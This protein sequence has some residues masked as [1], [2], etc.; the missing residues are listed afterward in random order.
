MKSARM[1]AKPIAGPSWFRL[2]AQPI[3]VG[4]LLAHFVPQSLVSL[5][6]RLALALPFFKSGLTRWDGFLH[7]SSTTLY[8]FSDEFRLHLGFTEAALPFPV[9]TAYMAAIFEIVLP[10]LLVLGLFTRLA[11]FGLLGMTAVIEL[12]YP[13]AWEMFH[14]PWACMALGII[15]IGAGRLSLDA[16]IARRV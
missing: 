13:D 14:L 6:L 3:R 2:L 11:A 5:V 4:N 1:T 9:L 10:I 15:V 7:V 8:L 16:E 12:I